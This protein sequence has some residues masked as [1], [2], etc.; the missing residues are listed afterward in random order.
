MAKKNVKSEI[1]RGL[2]FITFALLAYGLIV[3]YSASTV[4]SFQNFGNTYHYIVHQIVFGA[5]LGL[6]AMYIC[7]RIEYH[8]W[9]K[10]LPVL[11]A[12]SL[13]F[14]ALVKIPHI[15]FSAGGASRWVHFGP[16]FFQPAE[17]AKMVIILYLASWVDKKRGQINDFY[18]GL[19]PSL[20]I[21]G[22]FAA[23]ILWQPD[24]ALCWCFWGC[25]FAC[26]SP[27]V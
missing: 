5:F 3:L 1:D 24:L 21:V 10:N 6:L 17:L 8:F 9:Q 20:C 23:L 11:I 7:S 18:Y 16:I 2:L 4:E 19:L 22:L 26:C 12:F 13:L 25:L 27:R 14:L 15:G